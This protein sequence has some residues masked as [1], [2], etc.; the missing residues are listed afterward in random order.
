MGLSPEFI[1]VDFV[2]LEFDGKVNLYC[3]AKLKKHKTF[4]K[5]NNKKFSGSEISSIEDNIMGNE[6]VL[7]MFNDLLEIADSLNFM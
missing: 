5:F 2:K 4:K 1:S 3:L 6:I 7:K